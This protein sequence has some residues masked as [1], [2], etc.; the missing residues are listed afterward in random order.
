MARTSP[1]E[2][3]HQQAEAAFLELQPPSGGGDESVRLVETY[4]ELHAEYAAIRR[5]AALLDQ[6]MRA[7]V[8]VEGEDRLDF[9]GRM[10]TQNVAALPPFRSASSFWLSRKGRIDADLRVINLPDRTL[11]ETD[12]WAAPAAVESLE[13]YIFTEDV[14][15]TPVGERTHR[16]AL[17]GPR[18]VPLLDAASQHAQGPAL[19][20]LEEDNACVVRID[21]HEVVV[22]RLDATGDVGLELI[23]PVGAAEDVHRAIIT[24]MQ[25]EAP[26]EPDRPGAGPRARAIG[27]HAFN[28]ARL[29][30]GAPLFRI[31]FGPTNLPHETGV[32]HDRVD[33]RKGCYL[34]QEV[35]ARMESL[36]H[37]KQTLRRLRVDATIENDAQQPVTGDPVF[38]ADEPGASPIGAVTSSGISPMLGG[39]VICFAQVKWKHADPGGTLYIDAGG[40]RLP[41]VVE[42][43]LA[44]WTRASGA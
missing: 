30:A 41:A 40:A 17:H 20:E 8:E 34:G 18:A 28:M 32:L 11:L 44:S 27:W 33:F 16:L 39:A 7:V 2:S 21:D 22:D 36:G 14:R 15:F 37:P 24:A 6:P 1:L 26:E 25:A 12:V 13:Q 35:V 31:D 43:S 38:A 5:A 42:E 3:I 29:E 23:L 9:L 10:I 19:T 4:G